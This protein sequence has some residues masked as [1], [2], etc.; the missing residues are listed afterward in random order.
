MAVSAE[1]L[2]WPLRG[3]FRIAYLQAPQVY[4]EEPSALS[5]LPM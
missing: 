3:D 1:R 5:S 2:G 4:L